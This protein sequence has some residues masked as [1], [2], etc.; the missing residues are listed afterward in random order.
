MRTTSIN[1]MRTLICL[2][3]YPVKQEI[4]RESQEL[5]VEERIYDKASKNQKNTY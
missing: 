2:N 5:R 4:N 1:A 3:V